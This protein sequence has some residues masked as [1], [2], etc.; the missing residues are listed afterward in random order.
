MPYQD[1]ESPLKGPDE[2]ELPRWIQI[3]VGIVLG[4]LT[5]FCAFASI[6]GL[7]VPGSRGPSPVLALTAGLVLLLA[8]LWVIEKCL[9]LM[10]GRKNK[11][12]LLSP[13]ALRVVAIC[14]LI[15]PVAGLFTGYYR[16][17]G[18]IAGFQALM[19]VSGFFGLRALARKR[20]AAPGDKVKSQE[21]QR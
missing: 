14:L 16:Q 17:M 19:Y 3:P 18:A 13:A 12:G 8:C 11:G 6:A 5:L 4:L 15:I 2:P 7:L 20:E 21:A 10:T 9:R 1:H